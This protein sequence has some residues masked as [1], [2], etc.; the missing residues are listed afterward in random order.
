[1]QAQDGSIHVTYSY[2]LNDLPE[3]AAR[4]TIKHA[5]FN[6]AWVEQGDAR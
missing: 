3:G 4:K 5:N 6:A 2:F 1:M